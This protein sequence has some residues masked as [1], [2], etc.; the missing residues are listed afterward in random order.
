MSLDTLVNV[1]ITT[2]TTSL[3]RAGFGT[4]LIASYHT[5]S[6]GARVKTYGTLD[7][8]TTDGFATTDKEYLAAV[9]FLSQNP[10]V[11]TWKVGRMDLAP[12]QVKRFTPNPVTGLQIGL[13][14]TVTVESNDGTVTTVSYTVLSGD[15]VSDITA[16]L[17]LALN[18]ITGITAVDNTTHV[19]VTADTP[20]ELF[21]F[22][23]LNREL[24]MLDETADPGVSTDLAAIRAEDADWYGLILTNK[25]EAIVNPT[26]LGGF[27]PGGC[28]DVPFAH[29]TC[30][31]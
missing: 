6:A 27:L 1:T 18:A 15:A 17:Q 25:S 16:A 11:P 9:A 7:E 2:Q 4:P 30:T 24:A 22:T 28:R 26:I 5:N 8:M 10:K 29:R 13:I 19:T 23:A 21:G 31:G 20:G 14:H 3:S 12:T